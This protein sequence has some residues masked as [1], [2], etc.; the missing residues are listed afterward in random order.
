[1]GAALSFGIW[2]EEDV[3]VKPDLCAPGVSV[4]SAIPTPYVRETGA[5]P[6]DR[7]D[8][9]SMAAPHVSGTAAL[10]WEAFP[11]ASVTQIKQAL[12]STSLALGSTFHNMHSGHG[13]IQPL[14][15]L[16]KLEQIVSPSRSKPAKQRSSRISNLISA[17]RP[18]SGLQRLYL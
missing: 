14:P 13:L 18:C 6:Y 11:E 3:Y 15:A 10:L 4:F 16:R 17:S 5:D 12:Y 9:T 7:L 1:M 8:G 2:D